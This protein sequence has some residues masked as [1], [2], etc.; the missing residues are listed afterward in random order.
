MGCIVDSIYCLTNTIHT[1]HTYIL[2]SLRHRGHAV[3]REELEGGRV[4]GPPRPP[5]APAS[6]SFEKGGLQS[7]IW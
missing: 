5:S 2:L 6:L 4:V 1:I 7:C 3:E